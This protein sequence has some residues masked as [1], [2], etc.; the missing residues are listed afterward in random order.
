MPIFNP[1]SD[2]PLYTH[3]ESVR[4]ERILS[5]QAHQLCQD[6]NRL[7]DTGNEIQLMSFLRGVFSKTENNSMRLEDG[8]NIFHHLKIRSEESSFNT[9][10]LSQAVKI[11]PSRYFYAQDGRGNT[12]LHEAIHRRNYHLTHVL[13]KRAPVQSL[14]LTNNYF[15]NALDKLKYAGEQEPNF[16]ILYHLACKKSAESIDFSRKNKFLSI[17]SKKILAKNH[18]L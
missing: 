4:Y 6:M 18:S 3:K 1:R 10:M 8:M 16:K 14:Y 7:L 5:P 17:F 13:L 15:E 9:R 2:R 12:L 11:L